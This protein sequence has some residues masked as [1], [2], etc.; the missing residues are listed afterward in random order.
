MLKTD[1][2]GFWLASGQRLEIISKYFAGQTGILRGCDY[3]HG[4]YLVQME[5]TGHVLPFLPNELIDPADGADFPQRDDR[6]RQ[7]PGPV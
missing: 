2:G 5:A 6:P 7:L 4:H 3:L 1:I